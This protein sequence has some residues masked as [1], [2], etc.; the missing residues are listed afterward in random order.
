MLKRCSR[1]MDMTDWNNWREDNPDKEVLLEGAKFVKD[2]FED[3]NLQKAHLAGADLAGANLDLANLEH[4]NLKGAKLQLAHFID[5]DLR[6][7]CLEGANLRGAHLQNSDLE[8]AHLENANIKSAR[9]EDAD[10]SGTHLEGAVL[11]NA[12]L[13]RAE[14]FQAHLE[15]ANLWN[16]HL[17]GAFLKGA[18]LEGANLNNTNLKSANLERADLEGA[19]FEHTR[20][21]DANLSYAHMQGASFKKAMVYGDTLIWDCKIDKKTDFTGVGLDAARV[22]PGLK[23]LLQYNIRRIGWGKW[24]KQHRLLTP[25]VWL[26][27]QMSDY[28]RSTGRVIG[29]FF[30]LAFAFAGVYFTVPGLVENLH[31]TGHWFGDLVRAVYFSIVTM[32]TLGFGDMYAHP[33][34]IAG[35]FLLMFQVLL[36]YVLLGALITRF[37]VL[38]T[39]GGPAGKFADE[40]K[41]RGGD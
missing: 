39:A 7:A 13:E 24:Y 26:F 23:Q 34:S 16:A 35:H 9:L 2:Q 29:T 15:G 28:G 27:W 18:Y 5:A 31:E 8:N 41:T 33:Q 30:I 37:A 32:T 6:G 3:A 25:L 40:K 21:E 22:E 10:L 12:H 19:K 20:L 1:K 4:A 17:E 11:R 38:F 36:G 14:L